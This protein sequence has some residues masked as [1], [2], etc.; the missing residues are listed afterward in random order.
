MKTPTFREQYDKIVGAYLRD[1]LQPLESCACFVGNLL[2]NTPGWGT[3]SWFPHLPVFPPLIRIKDNI[4]SQ[5][6]GLY[7]LEDIQT[8]EKCFLGRRF[9]DDEPLHAPSEFNQPYEDRLYRA[10]ERTLLL[11]RQIHESKGEVIE[12]YCFKKRELQNV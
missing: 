8:L 10:M 4:R 3:F 12:D 6:N 7:S 1:E 2:N 9:D 11:L 5:S